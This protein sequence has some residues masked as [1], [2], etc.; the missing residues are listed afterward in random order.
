MRIAQLHFVLVQKVLGHSAFDC[1]S[2]LQLQWERLHLSRTTGNVTNTVFA[3]HCS[4]VGDFNLQ[5]LKK[6]QTKEQPLGG[7]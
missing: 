4:T 7:K 6:K 5:T 1:L 2:I 3:P